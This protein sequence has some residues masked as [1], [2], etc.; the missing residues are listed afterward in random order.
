MSGPHTLTSHQI[1]KAG[2][3]N[4]A[5]LPDLGHTP[6]RRTVSGHHMRTLQRLS[7]PSATGP[8]SEPDA[9]TLSGLPLTP[10]RHQTT[11]PP[12]VHP[13]SRIRR[14][15]PATPRNRDSTSS[16]RHKNR[17]CTAE[18]VHWSF[19]PMH[20]SKND[21]PKGEQHK[22][23]ALIRSTDLGFPPEVADRGLELL[24]DNAFKKQRHRRVPPSPA[25][26]TSREQGFHPDLLDE[27]P[28]SIMC[29]GRHRSVSPRSE[30][31]APARSL[32]G[33]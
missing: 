13:S 2:G 4:Q 31:A 11:P 25:L 20:P 19:E 27:P 28:S 24:Y 7:P 33:G 9:S 32:T 17:R 3:P 30:Q 1:S 23:A 10:P 18:A 8:S 14:R 22:N 5:A 12:Y 6:V 15:E 29:T 26:A 16:M 21:V